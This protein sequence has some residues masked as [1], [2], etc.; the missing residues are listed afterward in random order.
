MAYSELKLKSKGHKLSDVSGRSERRTYQI[1]VHLH[2][3]YYGLLFN[4]FP[5]APPVAKY[6]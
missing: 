4:T 6:T 1:Y 2:Y 3:L 5:T